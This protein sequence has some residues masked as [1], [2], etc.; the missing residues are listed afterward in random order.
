MM[1]GSYTKIIIWRSQSTRE[2]AFRNGRDTERQKIAVFHGRGDQWEH[3]L[4]SSVVM[5]SCHCPH[6]WKVYREPWWDRSGHPN[7]VLRRTH[8]L[9][10]PHAV[11]E[12]QAVRAEGAH[13]SAHLTEYRLGP[14]WAGE[15]PFAPGALHLEGGGRSAGSGVTTHCWMAE[16]KYSSQFPIGQSTVFQRHENE[17]EEIRRV[18]H[19]TGMQKA[20]YESLKPQ[21]LFGQNKQTNK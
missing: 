1:W 10:L 21:P 6:R 13:L 4:P 12:E 11:R 14:I 5:H 19:R 20:V 9:D 7:A 17:W 2:M 15:T 3:T 16:F 18:I 8:K